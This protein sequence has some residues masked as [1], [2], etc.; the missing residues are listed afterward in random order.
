MKPIHEKIEAFGQWLERVIISRNQY[1]D[2]RSEDWQ[3]SEKGDEYTTD[4]DVLM[5]LRD[6][7]QTAEIDTKG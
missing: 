3:E 1:Y 7:V 5:D 6:A 2:E 4:T